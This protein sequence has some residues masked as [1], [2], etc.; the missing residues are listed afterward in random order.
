MPGSYCP[1]AGAVPPRRAV[2]LFFSVLWASWASDYIV[3]ERDLLAQQ[4]DA[5]ERTRARGGRRRGIIAVH[6][7]QRLVQCF[8]TLG[9]SRHWTPS[10]SRISVARSRVIDTGFACTRHRPA[11]N[12]ALR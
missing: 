3:V 1:K 4:V 11:L 5:V 12:L 8:R 2:A 7:P 9:R 6:G 10:R